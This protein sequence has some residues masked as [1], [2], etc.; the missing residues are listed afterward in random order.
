M[1]PGIAIT[2]GEASAEV[3]MKIITVAINR[4]SEI[5]FYFSN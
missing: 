1:F 4:H 2:V 3:A 5:N